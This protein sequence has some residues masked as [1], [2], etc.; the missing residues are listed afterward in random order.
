MLTLLL[1][2]LGASREDAYPVCCSDAAWS[3]PPTNPSTTKLWA[4]LLILTARSSSVPDI[5]LPL[6]RPNSKS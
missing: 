1:Q 6:T 2:R 5:S 4:R 3:P